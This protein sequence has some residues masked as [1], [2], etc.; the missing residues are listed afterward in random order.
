MLSFL[1]LNNIYFGP[2]E[3]HNFNYRALL[4]VIK[5]RLPETVAKT[6][7]ARLYYQDLLT[8]FRYPAAAV[9]LAVLALEYLSPHRHY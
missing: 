3:R 7:L 2:Q 9:G 6:I 8:E 5:K 1:S 4:H